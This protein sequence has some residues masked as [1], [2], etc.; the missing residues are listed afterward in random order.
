MNDPAQA[1][2]V[3][4]AAVLA[5]LAGRREANPDQPFVD[6]R[7]I[8]GEL[9]LDHETTRAIL[10]RLKK[11][12]AILWKWD[13]PGGDAGFIHEGGGFASLPGVA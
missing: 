2:A 6:F 10:G 1:V 7:P 12:R 3:I 5:I 8:S 13:F 9:G 4:E 11:R